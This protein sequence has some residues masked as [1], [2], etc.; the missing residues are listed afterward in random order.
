MNN[1]TI[2]GCLWMHESDSVR[3]LKCGTIRDAG[4]Q[5]EI[6]ELRK[7]RIEAEFG[8]AFMNTVLTLAAAVVIFGFLSA[9]FV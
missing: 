2:D 1:K 7:R 9:V 5:H 4:D 3:C 8:Q 6:C